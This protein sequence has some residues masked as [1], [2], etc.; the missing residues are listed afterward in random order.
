MVSEN[1]YI[2]LCANS[3]ETECY[4]RLL[5]GGKEKYR[6]E[7]PTIKPGDRLF[8]FN[9][10][11]GLLHGTFSATSEAKMNIQPEAWKGGFP[12][13]VKVEIVKKYKPLSR[14]DLM[15]ILPFKRNKYPPAKLNGEQLQKLE[16]VFSSSKRLPFFENIIPHTCEDGHR[17]RSKGE[18]IIDNWLYQKAILH[19][20]EKQLV[21]ENGIPETMYCDFYIPKQNIYIEYWGL[22]KDKTYKK[23]KEEK[24][25]FYKD[26]NIKLIE[27]FPE[28][29]KRIDEILVP[30][31]SI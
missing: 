13:Q 3:T 17:V 24:I 8:L 25:N 15:D 6:K 21:A 20:Y 28:D 29:L 7:I 30:L 31:T 22:A 2:F 11:E 9:Y 10:Q 1:G 27:I 26:N 4:D 23:R 16:Q 14:A 5:F 12:W 18:V 19:A